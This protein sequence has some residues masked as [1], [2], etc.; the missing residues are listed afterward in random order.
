MET[1]E[2][3]FLWMPL[4]KLQSGDFF[5]ILSDNSLDRDDEL[6]APELLEKWAKNK[7]LPALIDHKN[8]MQNWAG[9][10]TEFNF[11]NKSEEM[12]ALTAKLT[13]LKS[14]PHT[15][16]IADAIAEAKEK[17]INE[18]GVSIGAIPKGKP[19]IVKRNGREYKMW[20]DAELIEGTLTPIGSNRNSFTYVAKSFDINKFVK[21]NTSDDESKIALSKKEEEMIKMS[22]D[23]MDKIL[24]LVQSNSETL[25]TFKKELDEVKVK[26]E[27]KI[28]PEP[29][30]EPIGDPEESA[31]PVVTEPVKQLNR[32]ALLKRIQVDPSQIKPTETVSK[33][34]KSYGLFDTLAISAGKS[35]LI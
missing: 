11:I 10:W 4:T 5:G 17:G 25:A 13:L 27:K 33:L 8:S 26:V 18:V 6:M 15:A 32:Q 22:E 21:T 19:K 34:K 3:R 12:Y 24:E 16:W 2:K 23:K 30:P 9:G 14:N 20:T 29:T 7:A 28:E 35:N 31:E 1:I